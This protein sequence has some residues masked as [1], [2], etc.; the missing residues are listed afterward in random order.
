MADTQDTAKRK[1]VPMA[2]RTPRYRE[3]RKQKF[4]RALAECGVI[5]DAA[6]VAGVERKTVYRWREQDPD[7]AKAWDEAEQEAADKLER[8]AIRR[9]VEGVEEPVFHQGKIVGYVRKYSD[10]L[11][12][13]LL[14]GYKPERYKERQ[15]HELSGPGG[16][17]IPI[18]D[19][20]AALQRKLDE[21]AARV[22]GAGGADDGQSGGSTA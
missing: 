2:G 6:K 21:L 13:F 5:T 3:Q 9:A 16:G 15:A 12:I 20:R 17:P 11:L 14:K 7:F 10:T 18:D 8:E 1:K 22:G 19:V 4:L